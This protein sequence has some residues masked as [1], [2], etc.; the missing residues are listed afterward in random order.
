MPMVA[1]EDIGNQVAR[2]LAGGWHGTRI[3]ELGSPTSPDDLARAMG[4]VL[5][6]RVLARAVPREEW[7]ATL[8]ARGLPPGFILPYTEMWDGCNAG[9]IAFG[10]PGTEPAAATITPAQLFARV[11]KA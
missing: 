1:T 7:E 3:V 8:A 10:V 2:L 5:G 9:W 4:E 6:R 11:S